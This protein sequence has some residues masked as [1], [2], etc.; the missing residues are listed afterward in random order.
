MREENNNDRNMVIGR[1]ATLE[2]FR[3]EKTIDKLYIQKGIND[4]PINS[5][6][7]EAKKR[8]VYIN[9]VDKTRLDFMCSLNKHQGV[10]AY[11]AS[12]SYASVDDILKK[13]EEKNEEPFIVVLDGIEDPHNLGA[14]IRTANLVGA[15]GVI[16][17]RHRAVGLTETV[18]KASA[19]AL[20]HTLIAKVV[21]ISNTLNHLKEKGIWCVCADMDGDIMYNV[22]MKGKIALVVGNEGSGVSPLVKKNCDLMARIPMYG[23][24]DSLNASVA[25]SVLSYEA[26]RQRRS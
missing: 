26:L 11:L 23:D 18:N 10:L 22:N 3:S 24:I 14:I 9:Y 5:I 12:Y 15:H 16:I 8:D 1:N 4:G 2:A 25:F 13:A 17:P 20:N 19:G 21:N 6:I 7:R